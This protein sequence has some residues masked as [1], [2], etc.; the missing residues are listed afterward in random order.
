MLLQ[1]RVAGSPERGVPESESRQFYPVNKL[2][3]GINQV[4]ILAIRMTL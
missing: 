1:S 3:N 4:D 2:D